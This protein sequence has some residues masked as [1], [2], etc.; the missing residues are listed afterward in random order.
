[1]GDLNADG[2]YFDEDKA[3]SLSGGEYCWLIDN[4]ID[5]TNTGSK[6]K[7]LKTPATRNKRRIQ[8]FHPSSASGSQEI[9]AFLG[10][11]M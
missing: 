3:S 9:G 1:M 8:L 6:L 7:P 11:A 10:V 4:G 5:T 2:S